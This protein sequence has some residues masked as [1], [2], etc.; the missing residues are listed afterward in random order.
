MQFT[1]ALVQDIGPIALRCKRAVL[2]SLTQ[3]AQLEIKIA[4]LVT[5]LADAAWRRFLFVSPP[6]IAEFGR[7]IRLVLVSILRAEPADQNCRSIIGH[8]VLLLATW[9]HTTASVESHGT[10][11]LTLNRFDASIF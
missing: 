10:F 6:V 5:M 4:H 2:I 9:P 7:T 3:F 8:H 1:G 11:R